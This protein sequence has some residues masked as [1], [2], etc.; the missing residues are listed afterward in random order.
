MRTAAPS[1]LSGPTRRARFWRFTR[2]AFVVGLGTWVLVEAYSLRRGL[3]V[4]AV[5][6]AVDRLLLF[7]ESKRWINYRRR[8][9]SWGA[10]TYYTL[11]LSSAFDPAFQEVV[12]VKYFAAED[13]DDSGG[14]PTPDDAPAAADE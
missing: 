13:R 9:L 11:E 1:E 2:Y 8:G 5:L 12:E 6:I 7:F 3:I 10:A 14:P 4:S